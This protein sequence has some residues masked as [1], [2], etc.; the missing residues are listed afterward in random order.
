M[1]NLKFSIYFAAEER[2]VCQTDRFSLAWL[3]RIQ[4]DHEAIEVAAVLSLILNDLR[5][6]TMSCCVPQ[7]Y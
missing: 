6:M 3:V 7:H 2:K 5:E 4:L 1:W